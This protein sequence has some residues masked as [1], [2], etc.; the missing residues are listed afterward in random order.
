MSRQNNHEIP[1]IGKMNIVIHN[2]RLRGESNTG[3]V[4]H[5]DGNIIY[6]RSGITIVSY[7]LLLHNNVGPM[8]QETSSIPFC[9]YVPRT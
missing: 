6:H 8:W 5:T 7:L 1:I 2:S 4:S 9:F 3:K